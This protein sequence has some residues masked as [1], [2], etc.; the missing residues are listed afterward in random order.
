MP[1]ST[2]SLEPYHRLH[3]LTTAMMRR[4]WSAIHPYPCLHLTSPP[5][6]LSE[7]RQVPLSLAARGVSRYFGRGHVLSQAICQ[8]WHSMIITG[9]ND[10]LALPLHRSPCYRLIAPLVNAVCNLVGRRANLIKI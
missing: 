5:F 2:A 4:T 10:L 8:L 3:T 6:L 9:R 7:Q 1:R